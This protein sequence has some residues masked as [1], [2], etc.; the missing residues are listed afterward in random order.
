MFLINIKEELLDYYIVI[1]ILYF[2]T[3]VICIFLGLYSL[4]YIRPLLILVIYSL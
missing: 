3:I 1:F 4:A 2:P